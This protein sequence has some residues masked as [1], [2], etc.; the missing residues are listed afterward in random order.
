MIY[1][2]AEGFIPA[3]PFLCI[4]VRQAPLLSLPSLNGVSQTGIS[5]QHNC[6]LWTLKSGGGLLQVE[7]LSSAAEYGSVVS[8]V[9]IQKEHPPGFIK[10]KS[11]WKQRRKKWE[12][13]NMREKWNQFEWKRTT[14]LVSARTG[15]PTRRPHRDWCRSIRD[16]PLRVLVPPLSSNV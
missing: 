9:R 13:H 16:V 14:P 5:P 2:G 4:V 6:L 10:E 11:N 8:R 3:L 1:P 12:L 15:A 7:T